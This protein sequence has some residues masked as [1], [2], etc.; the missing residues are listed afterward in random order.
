MTDF[1]VDPNRGDDSKNGIGQANAVRTL[2]RLSALNPNLGGS[3]GIYLASDGLHTLT[4]SRTSS[5]ASR[6][7]LYL[8]NGTDANNRAFIGSYDPA[9]VSGSRP[10]VK[11]LWKPQASDWVYDNT[12]SEGY[13][14]GWYIPY[15]WNALGWNMYVKVAGQFA[16]TTNQGTPTGGTINT[17]HNGVNQD[18]LRYNADY[19]V[20]GQHKLYLSG[21]GLTSLVDPT[22]YFGDIEIGNS[23]FL[24]YDCGNYSTVEG[25]DFEG[26]TL[27]QYQITGADKIVR[28]I[29][30]RDIHADSSDMT[31]VFA[32]TATGTP[33]QEFEVY[34]C[35]FNTLT[36]GAVL[37]YGKGGAGR[38]HHNRVDGANIAAAQGAAFYTTG[39]SLTNYVDIEYNY[40]TNI[41]NGAGNCSFDGCFAYADSGS[42]KVRI[43]WNYVE[44]SYKAF[45]L[46]HGKYGEIIGNVTYNCDV[47]ATCTDADLK[48]TA[49]YRVL[50]NTYYGTDGM[51][52]WP[53][54]V[55]SNLTTAPLTFTAASGALVGITAKNNAFI[56]N[57]VSDKAAIRALTN[58]LYPTYANVSNNFA[59]GFSANV[60]Q[61]WDNGNMTAGSNTVT[62]GNPAFKDSA[63][64]DLK[65]L[66]TSSLIGAGA[67][68][69][70]I[71]TDYRGRRFNA[72]PAIGAYEKDLFA[73]MNYILV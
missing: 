42:T 58:A 63:N 2:A 32:S 51:N 23:T 20:S 31:I 52:A 56:G 41:L 57:N 21:G 24:I 49:E 19:R 70:L 17:T 1:F 40:G 73:A 12:I 10:K 54:G 29:K 26:G 28:D 6:V 60:V 46:N 36:S 72:I 48:G 11:S 47:F 68:D 66:P 53:R 8:F 5:S 15:T 43:R 14:M 18:T 69:A 67:T 25:L 71:T 3:G 62:S 37:V 38:I 4:G 50:N 59:T 30:V 65:I 61:N 33:L 39:D 35:E 22:T 9:G 34:N 44:N 55:D 45:Q 7:G 16:V 64:G 13:P 27:L